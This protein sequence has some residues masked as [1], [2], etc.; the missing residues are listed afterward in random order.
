MEERGTLSQRGDG[1]QVAPAHSDPPGVLAAREK[2][3]RISAS[4]APR[5]SDAVGRLLKFPEKHAEP[6]RQPGMAEAVHSQSDT[7][8]RY[9]FSNLVGNSGPMQQVYE[10][11]AQVAGS[12]ATVMVRGESGT[13]KELIAHAIHYNSPR[14]A[15]PSL[16]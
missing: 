5:A 8:D 16:R 14:K 13:G 2:V 10:Q 11:I 1:A 12:N 9:D 3:G 7:R 6:E 15:V 4:D